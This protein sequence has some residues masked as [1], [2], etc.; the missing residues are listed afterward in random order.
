MVRGGKRYRCCIVAGHQVSFVTGRGI[1]DGYNTT[2]GRLPDCIC[3]SHT[4]TRVARLVR[5]QVSFCCYHSLPLPLRAALCAT[6]LGALV[7]E[8]DAVVVSPFGMFMDAELYVGLRERQSVNSSTTEGTHCTCSPPSSPAPGWPSRS[9]QPRRHVGERAGSTGLKPA[10]R[11]YPGIPCGFVAAQHRA[12]WRRLICCVSLGGGGQPRAGCSLPSN[13]TRTARSKFLYVC[14][15]A[16]VV[17]D[18]KW[19]VSNAVEEGSC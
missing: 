11:P 7:S 17:C 9:W 2:A 15:A 3:A 6:H 12:F 18:T 13:A 1:I 19:I 5:R 16:I 4:A 14:T 8:L 10:A